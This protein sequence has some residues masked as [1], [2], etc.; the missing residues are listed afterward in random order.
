MSSLSQICVTQ[1]T[2]SGGPRPG[3]ALAQARAPVLPTH[4]PPC[5]CACCCCVGLLDRL[6]S[7]CWITTAVTSYCR[8]AAASALRSG[9]T[10]ARRGGQQGSRQL[11][12]VAGPATSAQACALPAAA[13]RAQW[14]LHPLNHQKELHR[15]PLRTRP[16][17]HFLR[18]LK[19]P[20]ALLLPLLWQHAVDLQR[21][22]NAAAGAGEAGRR[23]W[24]KQMAAQQSCAPCW[25]R[26]SLQ[27]CRA[28]STHLVLQ[29]AKGDAHRHAQR[30]AQHYAAGHGHTRL[31][32][33]VRCRAQGGGRG[34]GAGTG[35]PPARLSR[36]LQE[37]ASQPRAGCQLPQQ[38]RTHQRR[39][40]ARPPPCRRAR[41]S[42]SR[43]G[44]DTRRS[45]S[46]WG[47]R[48]RQRTKGWQQAA[49]GG[50]GQQRG[51]A[52][53]HQWQPQDKASRAPSLPSPRTSTA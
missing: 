44:C 11:E 14:L 22:R 30:R 25:A 35:L 26:P 32:R 20:R 1:I 7:S 37:A 47:G 27:L 45:A 9:S 12:D 23:A 48:V 24:D 41:C 43:A 51:N 40:A 10:A 18:L 50:Q 8:L 38:A 3:A 46:A 21:S 28:R 4:F 39:P 31:E 16:R 17:N 19:P 42:G 29:Q 2:S 53:L 13:Q 34:G 5:C 33:A 6:A 49:P 15:P 52:L 36:L